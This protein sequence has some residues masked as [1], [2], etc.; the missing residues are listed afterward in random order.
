MATMHS[1]TAPEVL[2]CPFPLIAEMQQ[3]QP[4]YCDPVTGYYVVTRYDDIAQVVMK[5]TLFSN[6]T[7]VLVAQQE[8]PNATEVSR[9]YAERGYLPMHTLVSADPPEHTLYR[10]LIDKFFTPDFVRSLEPYIS[11]LADELI[12]AFID[13]GQVDFLHE[14][15]VKLPLYV[16]ADQ[17]GVPRADAPRFH[18]WSNAVIESF[19]PALT[20]ERELELADLVIEMQQYIME[21]AGVCEQAPTDTLLSKMV[22][23]E[24]S[25]RR[26][27]P[28]ELVA[29]V[30]QF[31]VAGH[32]TSAGSIA[33]GLYLLIES[34][35][36]RRRLVADRSLLPN[37]VEEVLRVHSPGSCIYRQALEDT[38]IA[39]TPVPKGS[40]L[41]LSLLG[42]NRDPNKF[43]NP[44][45][46]DLDRKNARQQLAFGRGIHFCIGHMLARAELRIAFDRIITRL[47]NFRLDP[48]KPKPRFAAVFQ[49]HGLEN[50]DIVF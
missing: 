30:Q 10:S 47:P 7:S 35:D 13:K 42:A 6:K 36:V 32:E 49:T 28:R 37:F 8:S 25:G 5:P 9:R 19:S 44:A 18:R 17:L 3:R 23:V 46:V 27:Q 21:R 39:G 41:M 4:V 15:A 22:H 16:I 24:I 43:G 38:E 45:C 26:L 14:F 31:M 20:P 11:G 40:I 33:N 34:P 50:L 48:E 2:R 12:D 1:F 29:I